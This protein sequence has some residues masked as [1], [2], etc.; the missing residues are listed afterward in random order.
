MGLRIHFA[1]Y[2]CIALCDGASIAWISQAK[3][4]PQAGDDVIKWIH[5]TDAYLS[6]F[7]M[8]FNCIACRVLRAY[9]SMYVVRIG[10]IWNKHCILSVGGK[11][12]ACMDTS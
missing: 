8:F 3:W 2:G 11:G 5:V 6:I 1:I 7:T 10:I 12:L 9:S 4:M